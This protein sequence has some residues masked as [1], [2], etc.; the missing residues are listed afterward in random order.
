[1]RVDY[2][3]DRWQIVCGSYTGAQQHAVD[4]LYGTV[5]EYVP[6][7]LTAAT[8]DTAN[9]DSHSLILVG[10]REDNP[11]IAQLVAEADIPADGFL[12]KIMDSPFNPDRQ[13]ALLAGK[14]SVQTIYAAA[15]FLHQYLPTAHHGGQLHYLPLFQGKLPP[16]EAACS[17]AITERGIWTWGHCIYDYEGFA[18]NMARIG[19]NAITIWN[20]YAPLNLKEVVSCFHSYGIKVIFGY[21]WAWDEKPDISSPEELAYWRQRVMDIYATQYESAGGDGIYFQSFTETSDDNIGGL[22]I[23]ETVVKWVNHVGGAMLDRWPDL[24][25]QF[26]LH[27]T[28]VKNRLDAIAKV[29]P[30]ICITW[31]DCGA[32]PY[33]YHPAKTEDFQK[34]LDFTDAFMSLRPNA[35]TGV[36]LK[37]QCCLNWN[38]FEHQKGPFIMGKTSKDFLQKRTD[39][40]RPMLRHGQSYWLENFGLYRTTLRH[41]SGSA[42][43]DLVEDGLFDTN[44]WYAVA[45]YALA[46]WH[47]ELSDGELLRLVAQRTDITMA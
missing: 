33:A 39:Y 35:Q 29:D 4:M 2:G 37:G 15:H 12:V 38:Q 8:A 32:F 25:I 5:K 34:T 47:P 45:L 31:E 27:A 9:T 17:P 6:Y 36:V 21:S 14:T 26:G 22:S 40:V 41:L 24:Y 7:I 44:C 19:L 10:T 42:V 16:Y 46:M 28:S 11:L 30:R 18:E 1:M 13:I 20:D 3:N 43:Y 23:A